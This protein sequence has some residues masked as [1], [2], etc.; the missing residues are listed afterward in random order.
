MSEKLI[1]QHCAPTLAGIKTGNLFSC[2]CA[3]KEI[4]ISS[5]REINRKLVPKGIRVL[6]LR[7]SEKRA[8]IYVY[9]PEELDRDLARRDA[10]AILEEAGY[11]SHTQRYCINE[12]IRRLRLKENFPHEIGLFL[13]YPPKDVQEFIRHKG[14][15]SKCVGCWKVYGD[16][17]EA[18]NLFKR[19]KRCTADFCKQWHSGVSIEKLANTMTKR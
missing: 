2:A 14:A 16:E 17:K 7:L 5:L 11:E 12:L 19:Y 6:P 8:L 9:R 13:S 15:C 1:V 3:S 18:Q 4:L 10:A